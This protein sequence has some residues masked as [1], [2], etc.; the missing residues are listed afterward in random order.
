MEER[1]NKPLNLLI[2]LVI[3]SKNVTELKK[4][5]LLAKKEIIR[6]SFLSDE[7]NISKDWLIEERRYI[8]NLVQQ[9]NN[10]LNNK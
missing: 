9:K 7:M 8:L 5:E 1:F 6:L 2:D 4:Y 10:Y 3:E